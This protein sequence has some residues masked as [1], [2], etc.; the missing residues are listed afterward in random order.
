M[1]AELEDRLAV[2]EELEAGEEGLAQEFVGYERL[3]IETPVLAYAGDDG[4]RAFILEQNP[5]Y[6]ESGGQISD[7]GRLSGAGWQVD[8]QRVVRNERG[9]TVV[10]GPVVDGSL[11]GGP[12]SVQA[13][14]DERTRRDTERNHTATHLLHAALRAELGDHVHQA[15]SLVAPDRLRFDFTHRGPLSR[16][17]R[18]SIERQV[19]EAVWGNE[20]VLAAHEPYETAIE[21]GAMALFGEKYGDVVRVVRVPGVSTEL[22]GGTHVRSTGQIGLFRP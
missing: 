13:S 6:V 12:A 18:R 17:E 19:N 11:E 3:E 1:S 2:A 16:E 20:P 5:F 15:G 22:C 21:A 10:A 9:Q 4:W 8:V 7:R 14:V